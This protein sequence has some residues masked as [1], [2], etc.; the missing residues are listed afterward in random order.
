MF[1]K[2]DLTR[3]R[4]DNAKCVHAD[5]W[6]SAYVDDDGYVTLS[7]GDW[8]SGGTIEKKNSSYYG[9]IKYDNTRKYPKPYWSVIYDWIMTSY[10]FE[11]CKHSIIGFLKRKSQKANSAFN[12]IE[13]GSTVIEKDELEWYKQQCCLETRKECADLILQAEKILKEAETFSRCSIIKNADGTETSAKQKF[14]IISNKI[15]TA[16]QILL[17]RARRYNDDKSRD[18]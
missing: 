2:F 8:R 7:V 17:E 6:N 3:H 13:N 9:K 10:S 11:N 18:I 4:Y 15:A 5:D 16:R 12:L 1:D 14:D